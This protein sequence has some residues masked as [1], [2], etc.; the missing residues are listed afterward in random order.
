MQNVTRS[1][2]VRAQYTALLLLVVSFV[3]TSTVFAQSRAVRGLDSNRLAHL[4][5]VFSGYVQNGQMAGSVVRVLR[6]GEV[7][8]ERAFGLRD[9]AL[10]DPMPTDAIFRIASQ[11][12]ALV[13]VGVMMLQERGQLLISEPAGN[14]LPEFR[15]TTVAE[16]NDEGGYDVVPATRA[17]TIRDLLTHTAGIGYGYG[18]ASDVWE[19]AGIQGWYF[20]D[21]DEPIRE[22]VR[23]MAALPFDAQPGTRF[24]Y[25][26][27]TDILGALVEVVSGV[28]LDEFLAVN[29]LDPLGMVDTH[30]YLPRDKTDRL[31]TVYSAQPDGTLQ[32]APDSPERV[33]QGAYVDGPRR[34]FSGGAGLLSTARDY[35]RFLQMLLNRGV[36]DG[37]RLLS[38]KSVELMTV[39][40]IGDIGFNS[41]QDMGLGFSIVEDRRDRSLPGSV[42]EFGWGG[43]Y[44]ST[45]WVDPAEG[46]VVV[47][48]TQLLP[49]GSIDDHRKLRTLIY[50]A[51]VD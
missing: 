20:A 17:I 39:N 51:V 36:L 40:Q 5:R 43:A 30:F 47:Y 28:P 13:S 3:A 9:I 42:G 16:P 31:A 37:K 6:D 44:H 12:K 1:L 24:V 10:N 33:A 27:N 29:I 19:D 38:P 11:T 49:A 14:Y 7:A 48:F 22:T 2:F 45:Y 21:R 25:G 15:E 32:R 50:Q 23:R 8:Y 41:G 46:M 35:A 4:E 18:P 26:Y 34:S